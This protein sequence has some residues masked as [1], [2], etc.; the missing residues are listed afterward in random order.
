VNKYIGVNIATCSLDN[1]A[2]SQSVKPGTN[3]MENEP[4]YSLRG[5]RRGAVEALKVDGGV[6]LDSAEAHIRE[7]IGQ[8]GS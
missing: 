4:T 3:A 8:A 2:G 5:M 7:Q 6:V 1:H